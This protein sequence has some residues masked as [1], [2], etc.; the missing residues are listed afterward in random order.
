V[1]SNRRLAQGLTTISV[2]LAAAALYA[3]YQGHWLPAGA[4][5]YGTLFLS[6]TAGRERANH[7]RALAERE[8]ALHAAAAGP[9]DAPP[10]LDPCCTLWGHSATVHGAQCTRRITHRQ[11]VETHSHA[12]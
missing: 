8:H 4:L 6:W 2:L 5:A 7:Q 9:F 1:T 12:A 3:G 10:P 11:A